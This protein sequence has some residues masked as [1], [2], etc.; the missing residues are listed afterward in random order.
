M[1]KKATRPTFFYNLPS[2][3]EKQEEQFID[4]TEEEVQLAQLGNM[5][6]WEVFK[7]TAESLLIELDTLNEQ[8]IEHGLSYEEIGKNTLVTSLVKGIIR[9]LIYKVADAKEESDKRNAASAGGE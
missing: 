5:A 1:A 8:A 6:G 2:I 7:K 3:A 9:R 4:L